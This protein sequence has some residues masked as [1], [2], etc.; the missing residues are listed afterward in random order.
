MREAAPEPPRMRRPAL[1]RGSGCHPPPDSFLDEE[2]RYR[3]RPGV[4]AYD[5]THLTPQDHADITVG[6]G[7][8]LYDG[9]DA[10][11]SLTVR[12][13]DCH[14][15]PGTCLLQEVL[16]HRRQGLL[17]A[18]DL[19]VGV[20]DTVFEREQRLDVEKAP[21]QTTGPA[22]AATFL[23]VLERAQEEEP[24]G[25]TPEPV[26]ILQDLRLGGA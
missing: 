1:R 11:G 19:L 26:G 17:F 6:A 10:F 2:Q 23:K 22:Y 12:D 15:L 7:Q 24:P 4:G 25:V 13:R 3:F 5:R 21:G 8:Q 16:F 14:P 9:V 18:A 20:H